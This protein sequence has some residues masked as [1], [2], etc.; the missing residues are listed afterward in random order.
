MGK[1]LLEL[2]D[3]FLDSGLVK[4]YEW[5][6]FIETTKKAQQDSYESTSEKPRISAAV[7]CYELQE[8][9]Q[10]NIIWNI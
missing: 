5:V 1:F 4:P 10:E 2:Y 8:D 9:N 3:F 6:S 7:S